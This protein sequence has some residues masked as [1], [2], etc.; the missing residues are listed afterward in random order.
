MFGVL[1]LPVPRYTLIAL[2]L[3][4][5]WELTMFDYRC[6]VYTDIPVNCRL[7]IDPN[8]ACCMVPSCSNPSP[9]PAPYVGPTTVQPSVT[10]NIRSN[11]LPTLTPYYR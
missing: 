3:S 7:A 11:L 4:L 5:R 1:L 8:D 10:G 6:A 9:T 2:Y